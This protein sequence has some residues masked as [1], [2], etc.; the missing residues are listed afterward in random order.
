M[1]REATITASIE[2]RKRMRR[3]DPSP[4]APDAGYE[5]AVLSLVREGIPREE[6]EQ[7]LQAMF[8]HLAG[9]Q[10]AETPAA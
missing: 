1:R 8:D 2:R 9:Q 10:A 6:A 5:E 4:P 7:N 3:R